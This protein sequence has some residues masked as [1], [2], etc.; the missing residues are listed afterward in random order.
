MYVCVCKDAA[1]IGVTLKG[2]MCPKRG[3]FMFGLLCDRGPYRDNGCL[4]ISGSQWI[5]PEI[6]CG[7]L[8]NAVLQGP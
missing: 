3:L 2:P 6:T 7:G 4:G 8:T 5:W 1:V